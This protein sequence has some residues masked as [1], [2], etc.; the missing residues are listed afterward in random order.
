ML[1]EQM[2]SF[3]LMGGEWVLWLLVLLSVLCLTIAVE[4]FIFSVKNQTPLSKIQP[5]LTR[6]LGGGE[7]AACAKELQELTGMEARILAAG[8]EAAQSGGA[9]AASEVV[10]GQII[11]EKSKMERGLIVIGTT[12]SN[13]P[14][15]G[16]FGTVLGIIKAFNDLSEKT[17]E[18]AESVMAGISE[19]LVATAVGLLVAIPAVVLYNYFQKRNKVQLNRSESMSHFLLS[20]LRSIEQNQNVKKTS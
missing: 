11:F 3:A 12:G 17:A 19:A 7:T 20:R 9:E 5:I 10:A 1:Q 13:A 18:G 6:F 16:L 8:L 4:R 14:F 2:M 15:V